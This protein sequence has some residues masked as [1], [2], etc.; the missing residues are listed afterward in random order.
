MIKVLTIS[1]IYG[2]VRNDAKIQNPKSA[3]DYKLLDESENTKYNYEK[4]LM[5]VKLRRQSPQHDC[6]IQSFGRQ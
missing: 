1:I 6:K 3:T 4:S 2:T 5:T